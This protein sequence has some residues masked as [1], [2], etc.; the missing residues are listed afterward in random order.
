MIDFVSKLSL[1]YLF[2]PGTKHL[3]VLTV[4]TSLGI[5]IGTAVVIIVISVMNGFQDELRTRIL[6]AIPHLTF[7]KPGGFADIDQV[8]ATVNQNSNVV[9]S[10]EFFIAQSI[11]SSPDTT[12]GVMIKGTDEN[13]ISII[14]DNIIEGNLDALDA[15]NNIILG[16]ALAFELG[17]LPGD[18]VS[19]VVSNQMNPLANIPRV[20]SLK[21]SGLFSVGSEIDQNYAL[22]GTDAFRKAFRPTNGAGIEIQ[23]RDVF[24]TEQTASELL[25]DLDLG[26]YVKVSSWDQSYGSLFRATQ[27]ER[28]MVSLL[29]SLILL[30]AIF[31]MLIS[32]NSL[33]KDKRSEI[34]I[35]RTIGYSKWDIQRVFLQLIA[36]IGIFG[37]VFGN[38]IG[39]AFSNNI[40]EFFQFLA[41]VFDISLMNT[42]YVDYFPS[43]VE[44]NE[45]LLIN[46]STLLI[47]FVFGYIPARVAA[48]TEPA[49][50]INQE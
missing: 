27:L 23:L 37:V 39:I 49:K 9:D 20:I 45:V 10:Q 44:F 30:I 3:S 18:T 21:V 29:M 43:R 25:A 40:T 16:D 42:Y 35:L 12:R 48:N 32:I 22:I 1:S 28:T 31:S 2:K 8:R 34:A 26:S 46:F 41:S 14:A 6:G 5:A 33:V 50:I 7:E 19:L 17:T 38:I 36:F 11:L 13:E 15:S 47:L 24:T 4:F